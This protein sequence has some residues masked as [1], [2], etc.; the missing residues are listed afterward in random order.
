MTRNGGIRSEKVEKICLTEIRR[1]IGIV[2]T[3][4]FVRGCVIR[5][6]TFH[7]ARKVGAERRRQIV[8]LWNLFVRKGRKSWIEVDFGKEKFSKGTGQRIVTRCLFISHLHIP[9]VGSAGKNGY[10]MTEKMRSETRQKFWVQP[11]FKSTVKFL[12]TVVTS[13]NVIIKG[14]TRREE[15][16]RKERK[17]AR[18]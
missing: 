3:R 12:P 9:V 1:E 17:E 13:R 4:S 6:L 10:L 7:R 2:R 8:P 14:H 5:K 15:E 11:L 18:I 16:E